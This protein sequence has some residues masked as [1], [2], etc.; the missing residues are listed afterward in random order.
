MLKI[1]YWWNPREYDLKQNV[2]NFLII[3]S[4]YGKETMI[5]VDN[6][7]TTYQDIITTSL[8]NTILHH[9]GILWI[10]ENHEQLKYGMNIQNSY[11]LTG[12]PWYNTYICKSLHEK[13]FEEFIINETN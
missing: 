12:G 1:K 2:V 11:W 8:L 5:H 4:N 10:I 3:C 6:L 7:N 13:L 9:V